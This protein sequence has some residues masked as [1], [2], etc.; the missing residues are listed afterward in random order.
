MKGIKGYKNH[1]FDIEWVCMKVPLILVWLRSFM[2]CLAE[3]YSVP[4]PLGI[5]KLFDCSLFLQ[6]SGLIFTIIFSLALSVSYILDFQMKWV[7]LGVF[8]LSV[9]VFTSEES[10]GT[11]NRNGAL[12]FLFLAQSFAYWL[13]GS[14]LLKLKQTRIQFSI[15]TVTVGYFLSAC[16]KLFDSG[17]W[18]PF[19]GSRITLQVLKSFH[20]AYYTNLDASQLA[21][22][23]DVIQFLNESQN[24]I[25]IVLT[26]ALLLEFFALT[27]V[28]NKIYGRIYGMALLLMHIGIHYFMDILIISFVY[29]MIIVLINPFFLMVLFFNKGFKNMTLF[30]K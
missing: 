30:L 15:E 7:T 22:A 19:D 2:Y 6:G 1:F 10:S 24:M 21:K 8:L 17:I 20:H 9:L 5:C 12:S 28:I 13:N 4:I 25:V 26:C 14:N 29:P 27:A 3:G 18:W 16:S 11:L 23:A